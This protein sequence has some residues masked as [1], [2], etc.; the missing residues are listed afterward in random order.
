MADPKPI[1]QRI[2]TTADT[3]GVEQTERALDGLKDAT[4]DSARETGQAE[5]AERSREQRLRSIRQRLEETVR[6]QDRYEQQ[7]EQG[8]QATEED[9]R[10]AQRRENRI[11]R[12]SSVLADEERVQRRTN[13]AVRDAATGSAEAAQ[14]QSLLTRI[15]G[16]ATGQFA[17][18]AT[19]LVGAGG[20]VA[21]YQQWISDIESA[22]EG[23]REQITLVRELAEARLNFVALQGV[24]DPET[25]RNLESAAAVSGRD[26]GEVFRVAGVFRSQFPNA[27][28]EEIQ[29]LIQEVSAAGQLTDAPLTDLA[30]GLS[31][32]YRETGD[33]RASGNILQES[34]QQAGEAEPG[35]LAAEI[36]RFVGVGRQIGGLDTGQAAG[37]AAAGTGLGLPNEQATTGL[38]NVLFAIRGKGTPE[39]NELL[40]QLGIDRENVIAALKQIAEQRAAGNITDAQLETLGGREAAPVFSA[41]ADPTKLE[42]FLASVSAVDRAQSFEGSIAADKAASLFE[43]GS[44]QAF[45]LLAKQAES[46]AQSVR[47]NSTRAAQA[48]AA[49]AIVERELATQI[50]EGNITEADRKA[51]LEEFDTQIARGKSPAVAA[52]YAEQTRAGVKSPRIPGLGVRLPLNPQQFFGTEFQADSDFLQDPVER[53]L[54]QGPRLPANGEEEPVDQS[55]FLDPADRDGLADQ[56]IRAMEA[57]GINAGQQTVVRIDRL[58]INNGTNYQALGNP[59]YDHLDGRDRV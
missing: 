35:R 16:D 59:L 46:E 32:L 53:G 23:L 44:I 39:G 3:S 13:E 42:N 31:V 21:A 51:I 8:T 4:R 52:N 26:P 28:A 17:A 1:Q 43:P 15:A 2:E 18:L 54:E 40:N 5:R 12:L 36:G 14:S 11:R 10:A 37:F 20:V 58:S 45:N 34:I 24:E 22:K 6:A 27:D 25:L 19:G 50:N 7:I 29:S 56:I 38:R 33:T 48:S 55:S 41:L 9:Q 57:R 30:Q 47:S 49:R